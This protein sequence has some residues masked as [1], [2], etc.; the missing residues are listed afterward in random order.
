MDAWARILVAVPDSVLW[1]LAR[2]DDDPAITNLRREAAARGVAPAR[3]VFA[4]TRP[5]P[6]YLGLYAH[7][8][9]FLDT[10]PY[11]AH[12]TASDALWCGCP[13]VTWRGETFAGR[14]AQSLL[15]AVGLPELAARDVDD[16]VALAV[17]LARDDARRARLRAYLTGPGRAS[18]LFDTAETTAALEAA[19]LNMA[20]QYRQRRRQ[21]FRVEPRDDG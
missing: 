18:A 3:L 21:P 20:G 10:W 16:Y 8:D 13:L 2:G 15:V 14:V 6:D 19:Y 4:R 17:D 5:N 1:L 7:A 12:T 11:N 9:L